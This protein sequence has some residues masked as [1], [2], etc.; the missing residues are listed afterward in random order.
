M[1]KLFVD[2]HFFIFFSMRDK[3]W[4]DELEN[5][6][7]YSWCKLLWIFPLV[8]GRLNT[9]KEGKIPCAKN[10]YKASAT[11]QIH[12]NFLLYSFTCISEIFV[13]YLPKFPKPR[14]LKAEA[15]QVPQKVQTVLV[16]YPLLG[17]RILVYSCT[18]WR[19]SKI[20]LYL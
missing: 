4:L 6:C 17:T 8:Q 10:K 7:C 3:P 19:N 1:L 5:Y 2:K 16:W 12:Y 9:N 15:L 11:Y 13:R 20:Y 14:Y 18:G